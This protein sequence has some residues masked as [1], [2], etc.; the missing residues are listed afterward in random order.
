MLIIFVFS[1]TYNNTIFYNPLIYPIKKTEN[2]F[3]IVLTDTWGG[4]VHT[5]NAINGTITYTGIYNGS[6]HGDNTFRRI[7]GIKF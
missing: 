6:N 5:V 3:S 7:I 4:T 2:S 1:G